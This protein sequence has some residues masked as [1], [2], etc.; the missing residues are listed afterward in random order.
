MST[1]LFVLA[2]VVIVAV[3]GIVGFIYWLY[4]NDKDSLR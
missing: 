3:V 1:L 4:H 2:G